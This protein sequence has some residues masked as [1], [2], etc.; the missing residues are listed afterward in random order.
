M[1]IGLD[2]RLKVVHYTFEEERIEDSI[3]IAFLADL[4]SCNYGENQKNLLNAIDKENPDLI[5]LGGDIFDEVMDNERAWQTIEGISEKYPCYYVTG[6]HEWRTSEV[7][8]FKERLDESG[9]FVLE[10]DVHAFEKNEDMIYICGIDDPNVG[11]ILLRYQLDYCNEHITEDHLSI[12]LTHRPE[13][14]EL[15]AE[16]DFDYIMAGHAHGGQWRIPGL[17]N[18]LYV[19]AQ[20]FFPKYAGGIY[21][22]EDMTLV[23]SRGLSRESTRIPRFY[24]R[25]EL[26]I[27]DLQ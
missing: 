15:Y 7:P 17:I 21:E 24:N 18:G 6:N 27:V 5:L 3:R 4:H 13:L 8:E 14:M 10:G 20:G 11:S 22:E 19:P 16:Y 2:P 9:V 12:L 23:L 25:P 1:F 26:V